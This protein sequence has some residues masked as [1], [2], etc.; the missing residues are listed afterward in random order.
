MLESSSEKV[1]MVSRK[2]CVFEKNCNKV[3]YLS[4]GPLS[5]QAYNLHVY[6]LTKRMQKTSPLSELLHMQMKFFGIFELSSSTL[7]IEFELFHDS[8]LRQQIE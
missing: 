7:S 1:K 4:W 2:L 3:I 6:K 8:L 5:P